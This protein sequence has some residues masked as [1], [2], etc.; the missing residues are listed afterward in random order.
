MEEISKKE[1]LIITGISYGQ[2][3]RWKRKGLIPEEWF[4]KKASFTGQETYFPKNLI[5]DR[6]DKILELRDEF[7]LEE[8]SDILNKR[9]LRKFSKAE[10]MQF[11]LFLN[12]EILYLTD[13][14]NLDYTDIVLLK[15]ADSIYKNISKEKTNEFYDF[16]LD[17]SQDI[18]SSHEIYLRVI[19]N[20]IEAIIIGD[21]K[22]LA[23]NI[24][25]YIKINI[26]E[27]TD[28]IKLI[29]MV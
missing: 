28:N 29:I 25:D 18:I 23:Y 16:L 6:I 12:E 2:L 10:V 4:V 19:N 5:L 3:Y 13:K 27:L 8:L 1:L 24:A 26:K 17:N 22:V 11:N 7:T 14:N 9:I 20:N 15:I 21:T